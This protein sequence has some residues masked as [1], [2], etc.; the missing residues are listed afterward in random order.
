VSADEQRRELIREVIA[1]YAQVPRLP[2]STGEQ[3]VAGALCTRLQDVGLES[4]VETVPATASYAQ[5][6]GLLCAIGV[7]AA[8]L[9]VIN[10]VAAA[11][12]AVLV[13]VVIVDDATGGRR[14]FR[15]IAMPRRLAYNVIAQTG[16]PDAARTVVVLAHHDAAPG[17]VVFD[18]SLLRWLARCWPG[19]IARIKT[20]PPTWLP[21]YGGPLIVAAGAATGLAPVLI[22]GAVVCAGSLAAMIDIGRR[23]PVPGANDN[24]SGV[25][26]LVA[27]ATALQADPVPGVRVILLSAGAEEALQEG[28]RGYARRHFADLDRSRTWFVNLESVGSGH[29]ALLE[30][31][32]PVWMRDYDP[33]F[34]DQAADCAKA[35]GIP[36][37][38]GLRS[39]N[40]TD[41]D[42]PRRYGFPV[43]TLVSLD[44]DKLIT[45][46]HQDSDLPEHVDIGCVDDAARLSEAIIRNLAPNNPA[47]RGQAT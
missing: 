37:S 28:I 27:V 7:L 42:V 33:A 14:W 36:L 12:L 43:A 39:R 6:M 22:A 23:P 25:A 1:E 31:E 45:H 29:L 11:V 17:G 26:G 2:T 16:D 35:L 20:S 24:L 47:R 46:Y 34:K 41:S 19:L 8:G 13:A 38:R 3:Q 18:Q 9:A 4:R 30:G 15:R 10:R 5:P 21:V 40:S 44:A 32:G